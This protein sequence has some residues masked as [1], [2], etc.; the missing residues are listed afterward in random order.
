MYES[1]L[2]QLQSAGL[3]VDHLEIDTQSIIRCPVGSDTGKKRSGWYRVYS[4]VSKNGNTY[5]VGTYGNWKNAA[6]PE[7]GLAIEYEGK[8]LSEEDKVA[9]KAKQ[10]EAQEASEQERITK[11]KNAAERADKIWLSLPDSGSSP[12]LSKKKV[13]GFGVKYS[14][15]SIVVPVMNINKQLVGLQFINPNGDKKFLTGTPKSGAFHSIGEL[16]NQFPLIIAEG[17]A[18][19]ASLHMA[20]S[21]PVIIAFDA[22]NIPKVTL[23]IRKAY[24]EIKLIIAADDDATGIKYAQQAAQKY[25][26][27]I[28]IPSFSSPTQDRKLT[29]FNDLHVYEGLE[30]VSNQINTSQII[31]PSTPKANIPEGKN[32]D[33]AT[34][35][36]DEKTPQSGFHITDAGLYWIDPKAED[37]GSGWWWIC[38]YLKVTALARI[39]GNSGW[40]LMVEFKNRDGELF[41]WHIPMRLFASDNGARVLEGLLDRGLKIDSSRNSKKRLLEYLQNSN[42]QHRVRLVSKLGW[43]AGAYIS[44]LGIIGEPDEPIH[45][46]S[47]RKLLNRSSISGSLEGW[48]ENIAKYCQDNPLLMFTVSIP[49]VGPLLE[50]LSEKTIGFHIVGDSSL[51]KSTI[52]TVVGSV[53]GGADYYRTWNTTA[54]ALETMAAEHSDSILILDEINQAD[55]HTV[56]QTVYQLGNQEGKARATDSGIGTRAQQKW[57]EVWLSNGEKT[58]EEIQKGVGKRTEAGQE[59]R[60]L[61][62]RANLHSSESER[63]HKGIYQ[64]LHGFANGAKLSDHLKLEVGKNHGHAFQHF[65]EALTATSTTG[66]A[67]LIERVRGKINTFEHENLSTEA[68]GQARRAAKGFALVGA[69]GELATQLGITGWKKGEADKAA[70]QLFKNFIKD[71]G[72]EGN[73]EDRKILEHI[74][75]ELTTKGESHF[76][77][78]DSSEP[79]VDTHQPRSIVRWGYRRIE[80]NTACTSTDVTSEEEFY[81]FPEVFRKE[82]CKDF[83]YRR[84]CELLEERGALERHKGKGWYY[85]KRIPGTG[86]K[87]INTIFI[88]MSALRNLLV[89]EVKKDHA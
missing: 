41:E 44:P 57:C 66:K 49:F 5:Y 55:P 64:E 10:K 4:V 40:G 28:S 30:S 21:Y 65:I 26:A 20:T 62:I 12:Y 31:C 80:E 8:G 52:S 87:P 83:N 56:G 1:V 50:W 15:G 24:P 54:A 78:W 19:A 71:R 45:Y 79:R 3:I 37:D 6:L 69:C 25:S 7:K 58:L 73:S 75:V 46:Y 36:N 17:Y 60:L 2:N 18:T 16:S 13:A 88:K 11:Q 68:S 74:M 51:G 43:V 39:E 77:R 42:P 14:R 84:A 34:S 82:I 35:Q 29:D 38:G 67:K 72:G 85:A 53:C 70:A 76:T 27:S 22:G 59:L 86:T 63:R 47:E 9:I 81:I 61:H 32:G 48:R 89:N 23:A 33:I